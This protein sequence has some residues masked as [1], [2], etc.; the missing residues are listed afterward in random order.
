MDGSH[1]VG[2]KQQSFQHDKTNIRT[3]VQ[4]KL[5]LTIYIQTALISEKT[6]TC[7]ITTEI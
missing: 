1:A 7:N 4:Y 3:S 2:W 5:L 6:L